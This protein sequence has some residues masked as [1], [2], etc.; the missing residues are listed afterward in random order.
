[1]D[2]LLLRLGEVF[3]LH[4]RLVLFLDHRLHQVQSPFV[5]AEDHHLLA[6]EAHQYLQLDQVELHK[7][8]LEGHQDQED[9]V[10][11]LLADLVGLV[12]HPPP[13]QSK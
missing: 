12:V 13:L 1:M 3:H 7:H 4:L 11:D 10:V 2:L 5:Q 9:L 6:D 8:L